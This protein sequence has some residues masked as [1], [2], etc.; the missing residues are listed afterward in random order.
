[1]PFGDS[2]ALFCECGAHR[3]TAAI[4]TIAAKIN[5]IDLFGSTSTTNATP[6]VLMQ[7]AAY[8]ANSSLRTTASVGYNPAYTTML[9]RSAIS[10]SSLVNNLYTSP[11]SSSVFDP[12]AAPQT[13]LTLVEPPASVR[14]ETASTS[15]SNISKLLANSS[16]IH[17]AK[18]SNTAER[19]R[20][21]PQERI[22]GYNVT[23]VND[24]ITVVQ[25]ERADP[26]EERHHNQRTLPNDEWL[27]ILRKNRQA[28]KKFTN[29]PFSPDASSIFRDTINPKY[30]HLQEY[31]RKWK[32]VTDFQRNGLRGDY[33]V[34]RREEICVILRTDKKAV[35]TGATKR[36]RDH[37][38]ILTKNMSEYV[39]DGLQRFELMWEKSFLDHYKPLAYF[40]VGE[41]SGYRVDGT[42]SAFVSRVSRVSLLVPVCFHAQSTC[43]FDRSRESKAASRISGVKISPGDMRVERVWCIVYSIDITAC[44]VTNLSDDMIHPE[45][46]EKEQQYNE[47]GVRCVISAQQS[48]PRFSC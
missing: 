20:V 10:A 46:V 44:F 40:S 21:S 24:T 33:D 26:V 31:V 6:A 14:L 37:M 2:T 29:S 48:Q 27:H 42:E 34:R 16:I 28:G 47:E 45:Q 11:A 19:N 18:I 39:Q 41:G 1:M 7:S 8:G 5:E 22:K 4:P 43:L 35:T 30:P 36:K 9:V 15:S 3:P 23:E 17:N 25:N 38:L 32:H 13:P 12:C